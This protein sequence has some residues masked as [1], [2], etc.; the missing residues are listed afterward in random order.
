MLHDLTWYVESKKGEYVE[1][2]LTRGKEV[3]YG[4]VGK[5]YEVEVML[6]E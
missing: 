3:V 6:D 4:S 5:V 2:G 1:V